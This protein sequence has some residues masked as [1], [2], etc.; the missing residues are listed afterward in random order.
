MAWASVT[1]NGHHKCWNTVEGAICPFYLLRHGEMEGGYH[2]K[3][4]G[5]WP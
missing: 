2:G 5:S 1:D 3:V 4:R